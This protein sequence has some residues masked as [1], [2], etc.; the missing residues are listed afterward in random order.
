[1]KI[2]FLVGNINIS[3][4]VERVVTTLANYF[5]VDLRYEIVIYSQYQTESGELPYDLNSNVEIKYLNYAPKGIEGSY[6]TCLNELF[7]LYKK[8]KDEKLNYLITT[9]TFHNVYFAILSPLLKYSVIGSHHEEYQSDTEKWNM[10]KKIFYRSLHGVAVLTHNDYTF[11]EKLN[12]NVKIIPNA[13]PF[14][15]SYNYKAEN[16][17]ILMVGRLSSEKSMEYGIY[18][19][20]KLNHEYPDWILEI[21]GEGP[22]KLKLKELVKELNLE[23][24]VI[25][26]GFTSN[27][28]GKYKEA[29]FSLLTSQKEGFGCVLIESLA[30]GIPVISFNNV[31]PMSI[32]E[33]GKNGFLVNKNDLTELIKSMECIIQDCQLRYTLSVGAY[34]SS[35]NY[36]IQSI[37]DKWKSL[38]DNREG[39]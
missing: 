33:H 17:K 38:L 5:S 16:K 26:S 39:I 6:K 30:K 11:Y 13:I 8:L 14:V 25:L 23:G 7:F 22:E 21:V 35:E 4:G 20:K 36:M 15:R 10:L 24:K 34:K 19:W 31:G 32:I 27:V 37:A 12:K 29:A 18:A 1:M 3:G 28:E 2:G 9:K